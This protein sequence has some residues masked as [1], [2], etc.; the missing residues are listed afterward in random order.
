MTYTTD[1]NERDR[2]DRFDTLCAR[3][4]DARLAPL[5]GAWLGVALHPRHGDIVHRVRWPDGTEAVRYATAILQL[6][7]ELEN[8]NEPT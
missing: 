7:S 1:V 5:G 8:P 4:I 3:T 6:L 2:I